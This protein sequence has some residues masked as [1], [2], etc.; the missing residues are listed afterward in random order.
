MPVIGGE[1]VK[2]GSRGEMTTLGKKQESDGHA[3]ERTDLK[4]GEGEKLEEILT[5]AGT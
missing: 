3:L 1:R 5:D 2:E 4:V